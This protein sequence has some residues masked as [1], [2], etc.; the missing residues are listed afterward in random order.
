[1]IRSIEGTIQFWSEG[2]VRLYGWTAKEAVGRVS[3]DL[4]MTVF[5]ISLR[6]LDAE[7]EIAGTWQGTLRHRTRDGREVFVAARKVLRRDDA[8]RPLAILEALTDLSEVRAA[9]EERNRAFSM[10]SGIVAA[11][12]GLIYAKD[13]VGRL[14]MANEAATELIG[15]PWAKV[16]GQ[17]DL[18]FL[19]DPDQAE[20]IVMNDRRVM[21]NGETEEFEERVG[22]LNGRPRIWLSRKTPVYSSGGQVDGLVGVSVEITERK[23]VEEHLRLM[24]HEL[25]HRV[26]NSLTAVQ[27]IVNHTLRG[28]EPALR[29]VLEDRLQS[30]AVV[31]DLLTREAW[32]NVALEEVVSVAVRPYDG[33]E[34][35][36]FRI[37][38]PPVQLRPKA[39]LAF[40]MALH[41][42]STNALKFG[43][44]SDA[45]EGGWVD[46][47]W[48]TH[49]GLLHLVWAERGGPVVA[50]PARRGFGSR[51][52]ERILAQ[53]LGGTADLA[54]NPSGLVCSVKAAL[55][56][57]E[58]RHD[59]RE[60]LSVGS[61]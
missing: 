18:E 25:N 49:L 52:I 17:T 47:N 61:L 28:T 12:P 24:V 11:T 36:A 51:L 31:H 58:A 42:L 50:P 37:V 35:Q 1:M 26:K 21:D 3:H 23:R 59:A 60:L 33:R 57:I 14:V 53:D 20:L 55:D 19:D 7:L 56:D 44:L 32:Q 45:A 15:K 9:E 30:M 43:S 34:S 16:A 38:G 41:E 54:F 40:A 27:S 13:M 22:T 48:T 10:L 5:P 39:A 8:G 29:K 2:C 6:E 46:I 4:L